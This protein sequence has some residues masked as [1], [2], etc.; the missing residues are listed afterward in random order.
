VY[1]LNG[2]VFV[3]GGERN[4]NNRESSQRGPDL[5]RETTREEGAGVIKKW[6]EI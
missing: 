5:G 2:G 4:S 1:R 6:P 3:I